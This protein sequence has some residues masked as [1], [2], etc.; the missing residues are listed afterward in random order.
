MFYTFSWY[1]STPIGVELR[2]GEMPEVG[3]ISGVFSDAA[4]APAK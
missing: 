3:S 1:Q 4:F 2:R